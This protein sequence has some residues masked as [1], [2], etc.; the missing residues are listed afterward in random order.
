MRPALIDQLNVLKHLTFR[1]I[2]NIVRV[3]ASYQASRL[4]GKNLQSGNPFALSIEPTTSCN[5]RCPEC[6][7]G[8]RSFTRPTGMLEVELFQKALDDC[9]KDLIYLILY[10]QGEPYL[11]PNFHNMVSLA[12]SRKLYVATSTN[13]HYLT[14]EHARATVESGL[15]RLIISLDGTDQSTYESYRIGGKIEKVLEGTKNIIKWRKKLKADKPF[16]VFQFLVTAKNEHQIPEVKALADEIGVDDVWFKTA[17]VYDYENGHE[18]I[19]VD[20]KYSRYRQRR[21]GKWDLKNKFENR[22]WKMWH[23]AVITWDGKVVPCCFDKDASHEMG[24]IRDIEFIKI[25]QSKK[26][27]QFRAK[28]LNNRSSIEMCKNCTEGTEVW[29]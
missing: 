24:N 25:W 20:S 22:C 3:V 18:L 9:S 26:Y 5:L 17:Q 16:V 7:S 23:S 10:F 28:L 12:K 15:D 11:H 4:T 13:A 8:L 2:W 29:V 27:N 6:P 14:D 21:D 1:R 19:P